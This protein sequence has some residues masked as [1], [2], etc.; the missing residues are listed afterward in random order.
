MGSAFASGLGWAFIWTLSFRQTRK[1]AATFRWAVFWENVVG[2][3]LLTW[4]LSNL[5]LETI[6]EGRLALF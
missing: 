6:F 4:A 5:H 1:F 3:G 2:I